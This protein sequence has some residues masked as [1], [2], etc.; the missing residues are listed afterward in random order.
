MLAK[1]ASALFVAAISPCLVF[2]GQAKA[3]VSV[4]GYYRKN[5]T[6]VQPYQRTAPDRTPTNNYSYPGNYNPNTGGTSGGSHYGSH[7]SSY[8]NYYT[9]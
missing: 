8:G 9:R 6:Y 7:G 4:D 5:G 2:L 1:T 3:Q